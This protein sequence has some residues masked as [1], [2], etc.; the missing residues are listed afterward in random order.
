MTIAATVTAVPT[1]LSGAA[2]RA[3]MAIPA[4]AT[5]VRARDV[6]MAVSPVSAGRT[7]AALTMSAKL[8]PYSRF[9]VTLKT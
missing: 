2:T 6:L 1:W 4:A 9:K 8:S 7:R 3:R 5:W